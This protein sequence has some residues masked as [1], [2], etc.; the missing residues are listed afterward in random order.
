MAAL[1]ADVGDG[2]DGAAVELLLDA[3][4]VLHL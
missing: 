4:A 1:V 2:E 3:Q